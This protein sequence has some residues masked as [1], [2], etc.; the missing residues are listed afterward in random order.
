MKRTPLLVIMA[1]MILLS[2][3][4]KDSNSDNS[5]LPVTANHYTTELSVDKSNDPSEEYPEDNSNEP[6][7]EHQADDSN[8]PP[9]EHQM[10]EPSEPPHERQADEP[11]LPSESSIPLD[12]A[13]RYFE[14]VKEIW[15]KDNGELWG[16]PLHA[17]LMFADTVTRHAVINMPDPNGYFQR[18]GSIYE[19]RLPDG[20]MI[21]GTT[22]KFGGLTWGMMPWQMIENCSTEPEILQFIVHEAFH[23]VQDKVVGNMRSADQKHMDILDARVSVL[24]ET[25]ALLTAFQA[26]G[27]RRQTAIRDALSIRADRRERHPGSISEKATETIEGLAMFTELKLVVGNTDDIVV[28]LEDYVEGRAGT[29]LL[30]EKFGYWTGALYGFLLEDLGADWK[31]G[32]S[33]ETNLGK[34]LQQAAGIDELIP[35]N[36]IDLEQYG[37]F[38]IAAIE[39]A[40]LKTFDSIKEGAISTFSDQPIL[41]LFGDIDFGNAMMD[42]NIVFEAFFI[43]ISNTEKLIY[44]GDFSVIGPWGQIKFQNGYCYQL[45][46]I[47]IAVSAEDIEINGNL[48]S[49]QTWELVLNDDFEFRIIGNGYY[50]VVGP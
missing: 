6:P 35:V 40:W 5:E 10:D 8:E 43:E 49:G 22:V 38:E 50:E 32:L 3:A 17:P 21:W 20:I 16:F 13:A 34:V 47:G 42:E 48:A 31:H 15:D 26:T 2:S 28:W 45:Y 44:F 18:N 14:K 19:G 24:L 36:Q 29:S 30:S 7:E 23:A 11:I 9:E 1:I 25:N 37:Y 27:S 41:R 33:S 12:T 39:A 4:C 46:P